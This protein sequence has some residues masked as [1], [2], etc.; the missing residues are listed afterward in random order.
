M[1]RLH[2][3]LSDRFFFVFFALFVVKLLS[4]FSKPVFLEA[5]SRER[6]HILLS[7]SDRFYFVFFVLFVVKLLMTAKL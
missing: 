5:E 4:T 2:P 1:R 6:G 3:R 7:R